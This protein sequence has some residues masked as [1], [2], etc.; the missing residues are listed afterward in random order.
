[1]LRV[2]ERRVAAHLQ[3]TAAL[4][5]LLEQAALTPDDEPAE[6]Y[7]PKRFTTRPGPP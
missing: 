1:M 5:A 6:L 7:C 2:L 4:A 3:R